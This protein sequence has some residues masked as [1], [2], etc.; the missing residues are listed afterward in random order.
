MEAI[1]FGIRTSIQE[2][3]KFTPFFLKHG[4]EPRLPLQADKSTCTVDFDVTST[5]SWVQRIREEI[6]PIAKKN[7]EVSQEKQKSNTESERVEERKLQSRRHSAQ[8]EY[9]EEKQD[10]A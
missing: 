3:T 7:V 8:D 9:A 1:H 5:I 2:S 6:Y 4:R 10:G